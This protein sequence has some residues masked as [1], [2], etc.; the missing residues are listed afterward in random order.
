MKGEVMET[1][2]SLINLLVM[3]F[4][5]LMILLPTWKWTKRIISSPWISAG[6]ALLYVALVLPNIA[7]VLPAVL[8]PS[9]QGIAA[10]LGTP[11]GATIAWAH[12]LAFDSF[13]GRWVYLDSRERKLSPLFIS[14]I[15]FFVLM[16]GP[17]G[18]L[19]YLVVK[20]FA[21]TPVST[22]VRGGAS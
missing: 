4:W 18:F 2:F 11:A 17:L 7:Q 8:T 1:L 13:V 21:R 6:A 10:L 20:S 3:P 19:L 12:F 14:P 5:F 16:L 15:L 22:V 9:A